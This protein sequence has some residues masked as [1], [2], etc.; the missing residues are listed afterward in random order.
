MN[1]TGMTLATA[2]GLALVV[3]LIALNGVF[4]AGEFS[5][6]AVDTSEVDVKAGAGNRRARAVRALLRRLSFHL[7]GA[8]LGITLTSLVLGII[9]E[10]T[11]GEL[12]VRA[13]GS[14]AEPAVAAAAISV[15]AIALVAVTQMVFGE[16][17]PKNLAVSR[18]LGVSTALAPVLRLYGI[19]A[20]P[21]TLLFNGIA[22]ATVRALGLR[23]TEELRI[24]RTRTSSSTW[25]ARRGT[26]RSVTRRPRCS[27]GHCGWAARTRRMRSRP[28]RPCRRWPP[29]PL[30]TISSS[31]RARAAIRGFRCWAPA[32]TTCSVSPR[33]AMSSR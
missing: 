18:P 19:I 5:L 8:Q 1:A 6:L 4:V 21:V 7:G 3:V 28:V 29:V 27:C 30:S 15:V 9:A 10:G 22:N 33:C 11:I 31:W 2:A 23:P 13:L 25:C 14:W 26:E 32:V 17:L 12:L 24:V 20:A 16:L